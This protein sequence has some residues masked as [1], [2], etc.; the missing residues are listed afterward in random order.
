M[1]PT[2]TNTNQYLTFCLGRELFAFEIGSVREVLEM[3]RITA[4]PGTP[5]FM[6]GVINLRGHVVPVIDLRIKLGTP[7]VC[8]TLDTCIIICELIIHDEP[9][10]VGMVV[11]S[12]REVAEISSRDIE[13]APSLGTC[14]S[15]DMLRGMAKQDNEFIMLLDINTVLTGNE[16]QTLDRPDGPDRM[17]ADASGSQPGTDPKP[18]AMNACSQGG[19]A[20]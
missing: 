13:P 4:V 10:P 9:S 11:D 17:Q 2:G 1:E 19:I 20:S 7:E 16:L 14:V 6:R 12:V 5:E 15:G 18:S 8:D 3:T